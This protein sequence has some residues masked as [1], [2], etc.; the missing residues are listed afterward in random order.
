M[1]RFLD[2]SECFIMH[3]P[4]D[5]SLNL[6]NSNFDNT[7]FLSIA[8][9]NGVFIATSGIYAN[10]RGA[11]GGIYSSVDGNSW[12]LVAE[13]FA[14]RFGSVFYLNNN[15][16]VMAYS[17]NIFA[18]MIS[19]DGVVWNKV[20]LPMLYVKD[21]TNYESIVYVNSEYVMNTSKGIATSSDGITWTVISSTVLNSLSYGNGV[22][23]GHVYASNAAMYY[24]ADAITWNLA[25]VQPSGLC[26]A[27][28]KFGN[29]QFLV[30][31]SSNIQAYASSD[32][33]TWTLQ[34]NSYG[35]LQ[36][37]GTSVGNLFYLNSIYVVLYGSIILTSSDGISWAF[38]A[39]PYF[40][41]LT[42]MANLPGFSSGSIFFGAAYGNGKIVAVGLRNVS[43]SYP[44]AYQKNNGY[45]TKIVATSSDN[46]NTW[47]I[48]STCSPTMYHKG[49]SF[50]GIL[51][52]TTMYNGSMT[53]FVCNNG[54]KIVM[55]AT[56]GV[57]TATDVPLYDGDPYEQ[58]SSSSIV[59]SNDNG[60]TWDVYTNALPNDI[61]PYIYTIKYV[62]GIYFALGGQGANTLSFTT[63]PY[64][65][66]SNDGIT[67]AAT[68]V[69]DNGLIYDV[70]YDG[71][72][73]V[74]V[75]A[76]GLVL[77]SAD[78]STWSANGSNTPTSNDIGN[79]YYANGVYVIS[80]ATVSLNDYSTGSYIYSTLTFYHSTN[81]ST[82]TLGNIACATGLTHTPLST[83][84]PIINGI[85]N[86]SAYT[87]VSSVLQ[88]PGY[89]MHDGTNFIFTS[90]FGSVFYSSDG[91][92]WNENLLFDFRDFQAIQGNV[93]PIYCNHVIQTSSGLLVGGRN[94]FKKSTDHGVTW[95][96]LFS[97]S[98]N[99]NGPSFIINGLV[100]TGTKILAFCDG[101]IITST[102]GITWVANMS[103]I[104][105][106]TT[107]V[108]YNGS[109]YVCIGTIAGICSF[110]IISNDGNT[111]TGA[112][113]TGVNY[114]VRNLIYAN[115]MFVGVG[116]YGTIITSTDGINWTSPVTQL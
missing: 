92:T 13:N 110:S 107:P 100:N 76:R 84:G 73:Y 56:D 37:F 57:P 27:A 7:G 24:S 31:M 38:H 42:P 5:I 52:N 81:A 47:S 11:G 95:T 25:S 106:L 99:L 14:Y 59:I 36:Y 105:T 64:I 91:I 61:S 96:D 8:F 86:F 93:A 109:I 55:L 4:S 46:G 113:F 97:I 49:N 12:T 21:Y 28:P 87:H 66:T 63:L 104:D 70:I 75:G 82:W 71:S 45:S 108:V 58:I 90:G 33:D 29:S 112:Y 83:S 116:D 9:G 85:V 62:N 17:N 78:A 48:G 2:H 54:T 20:N 22:F 53:R 101:G 23:V 41:S 18:L 80:C 16:F 103:L 111:W 67:W 72:T 114:A 40:N 32:G 1:D 115:S 102:D 10:S 77:T 26:S 74:A 6:S 69:S 50:S 35:D 98:E 68:T 15:F 51:Y 79:I 39:T 60:V 89:L 30:F 34:S 88:F 44:P 3:Y 43:N 94:C 19:P 65:Y